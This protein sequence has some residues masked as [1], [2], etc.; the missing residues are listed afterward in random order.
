MGIFFKYFYQNNIGAAEKMKK[1]VC[2]S[3][4]IIKSMRKE[5]PKL[6]TKIFLT[7][8]QTRSLNQCIKKAYQIEIRRYT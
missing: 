8:K 7:N 5:K 1:K 3:I 2:V 6:E 4:A